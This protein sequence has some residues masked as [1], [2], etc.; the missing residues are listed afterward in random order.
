MR[1][2]DRRGGERLGERREETDQDVIW[3]NNKKITKKRMSLL[4]KPSVN[5]TS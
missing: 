3:E 2:K 4:S 5:R 1:D